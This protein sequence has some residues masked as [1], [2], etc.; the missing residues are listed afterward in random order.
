[1][2]SARPECPTP[3]PLKSSGLNWWKSVEKS[4]LSS[5]MPLLA[6]S[7]QKGNCIDGADMLW[8]GK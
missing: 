2:P 4:L 5:V 3:V 7:W 1:M 8:F 6:H